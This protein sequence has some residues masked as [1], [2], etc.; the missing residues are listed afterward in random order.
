[1]GE[2]VLHLD[3][4]LIHRAKTYSTRTGR[5]LSEIVAGYFA[6]FEAETRRTSRQAAATKPEPAKVAAGAPESLPQRQYRLASQYPGEFVVLVGE[7][8]VYH[9]PDRQAAFEAHD[10]AFVDWPSGSPVIVDPQRGPRR[11]PIVRG[12]SFKR[13]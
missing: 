5:T 2:L 13:P 3:D 12:R 10:Q 8:V 1:M 4:D 7:E 9:S 6:A 11:R